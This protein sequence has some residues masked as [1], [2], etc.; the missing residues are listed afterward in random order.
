[1]LTF[2]FSNRKGRQERKE[3]P[4]FLDSLRPWRALR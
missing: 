1:M 3:K 2:D 4:L